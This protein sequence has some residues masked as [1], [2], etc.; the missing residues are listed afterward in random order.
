[1]AATP[2]SWSSTSIDVRVPSGATTGPVV[3]TVSGAASNGVN[4]TVTVASSAITLT[5]HMNIDAGTTTTASVAF[6]SANTA[7][8]FIAVVIRAGAPNEVFTVTDSGGNSYQ[9]AI[10]INNGSDDSLAIYYAQ[11]IVGGANSVTVSDAVKG[12]LRF[13]IL[14]YAGIAAVSPLDVT[15]AAQ[16][17]G[18]TASSGSVATPAT[19]NGDLLLGAVATANPSRF[20]AGSGDTIEESVPTAPATQ[21]IAEDA[22]QTA[23]GS[24]SMAAT[25]LASDSW[26]AVLAAFRPAP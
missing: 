17:R 11:N 1:V 6:S 23:A 20:S 10:E 13:A 16:G 3:M 7:G 5:Q 15:A 8:N 19:A 18:T 26:A 9:K 21:L 12:T 2:T 4:F 25:L 22:I 24:A 14:E